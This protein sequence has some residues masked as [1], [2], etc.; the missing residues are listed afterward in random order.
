MGAAGGEQVVELSHP[1]GGV[2][3]GSGGVGCV[4]DVECVWVAMSRAYMCAVPRVH[5]KQARC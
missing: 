2:G 5:A 1:L 3:G 4:I